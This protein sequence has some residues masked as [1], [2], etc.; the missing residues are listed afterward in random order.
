MNYLISGMPRCRT[1]WLTAVLRAHGSKAYHDAYA[2][3]YALDGD[4]GVVDPAVAL[5]TPNEGLY[6][7]PATPKFCIFA[8]SLADRLTALEVNA[9]IKF[10]K[11][12]FDVFSQN[13]DHYKQYAIGVHVDD[14][15][16]NDIVGEIVRICT[17]KAPSSDTISTFQLLK[18][19]EHMSKAKALLGSSDAVLNSE[20]F[21]RSLRII[22]NGTLT[23]HV[24]RRTELLT[25]LS[26]IYG[27]DT[28]TGQISE[29]ILARLTQHIQ[30]SGTR[31]PKTSQN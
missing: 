8:D 19:E 4:Y 16:D 2:R 29:E 22:T 14:L 20:E 5:Y 25:H 21:Q 13:F 17:N 7:D 6:T 26:E 23:T 31:S 9:G 1:A 12:A 3:G 10:S 28:T 11:A 30:V 24:E 18:V 15:E 27:S